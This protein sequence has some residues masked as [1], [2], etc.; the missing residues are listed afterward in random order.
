MRSPSELLDSG[1][2]L[3]EVI[4]TV[5]RCWGRS[6][7]LE[8]AVCLG[9]RR[10]FRDRAHRD[11]VAGNFGEYGEKVF[12]IPAKLVWTFN[13][14]GKNLERLP[15]TRAVF[16]KGDLTYTKVRE[17]AKVAD[18]KT[19][20]SW[21]RFA[22]KHTNRELEDKVAKEKAKREGR[23]HED[24]EVVVSKLVGDEVQAARATRDRIMKTT[25][26]VVPERDLLPTLV[27]M[28]ADGEFPQPAADEGAKVKVSAKPKPYVSFQYCPSCL[29]TFTPVPGKMMQ[30]S[31]EKMV[32]AVRNGSK[33]Y[34]LLPDMHCDCKDVVHRRDL[35]PWQADPTGEPPTSRHI[36]A[37]VARIV[38]ARD[39]FRCRRPGCTNKLD[40]EKGHIRAYSAKGPHLPWNLGTMCGPC[41]ANIEKGLL[42]VFG[43]APFEAYFDAAGTFLGYGFNPVPAPP[44][45]PHVGK[46]PEGGEERPTGVEQGRETRLL[47]ALP[48][49]K[50]DVFGT[51]TGRVRPWPS[52]RGQSSTISAPVTSFRACTTLSRASVHIA[53]RA[54]SAR[55][56]IPPPSL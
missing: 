14:I 42:L 30:T 44:I 6:Q 50:P 32:E 13:F 7:Y 10:L 15:K 24:E 11:H 54:E 8:Y 41:N 12:D 20:A 23:E 55:A 25:G 5:K 9:L 27:K 39:G 17:F 49:A 28:F 2:P 34:N 1:T 52:G 48:S 3:D 33:V 26:K 21:I 31:F 18:A 56:S 22:K 29:T 19:E 46:P 16:E 35:C 51:R 45:F 38:D 53:F 47:S 40:L 36:P 43:Y 37:E 4:D